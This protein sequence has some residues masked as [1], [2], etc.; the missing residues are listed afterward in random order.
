MRTGYYLSLL[1][2]VISLGATAQLKTPTKWTTSTSKD[3]IKAGDELDLIF[4]AKID[5]DWYLYSNDFDPECGPIVTEFKFKASDAFELVGAVKPIN[6]VVKHDKNFGCDVKIFKEKGEF[7][8]RIRVRSIPVKVEVA[9]SYQTCTDIDGRCIPGEEEFVFDK[10]NTG[11]TIAEPPKKKTEIISVAAAPDTASAKPD[12]AKTDPVSTE[13]SGPVLKKS[14]LEGA[15]TLEQESFLGFLVIAFLAGLTSLITPCIFPMIPMTVT[16]F[17]KDNQTRRQGIRKALI[18]GIS[19]I[20]IYTTL[21]TLFAVLLGTEGLNALATNWALNLFVFVI[22]IVFALSFFG[23]FEITA[24]YKL[25]NKMD[26]QAEKGGLTGI[27]FMAATLCLVSF[28]CTVPIVGS[29]LLLASGGAIIKPILVMFAYSVAFGVPFTI[30]AI[31]PEAIKRLPKSGGWLNAVKVSLGCLELALCFK[32]FSIADQ[33]YHWG[34]LDRDTNLALWI[35]IFTILGFYLLGKIRLPHDSAMESVGV[36]RLMLAIGVFTF[37][38]YLIP[39]LFGAPLKALAGYLPPKFTLDFDLDASKSGPA[40]CDVPKYEDFLHLPHGIEGYFDYKQAVLCARK[41]NKPVFIDFTG[42]GCTNCR[43]MEATVWSDPAVLKRLKND[44]IVVALYVDDKTEL[45]PSEWVT[46]KAD[47][48]VKKTIGKVNADIQ[49]ANL[50]N[51][52]QPYY[53]LLGPDETVLAWPY[54]YDKSP[55]K[56]V[57]FLER[58]KSKFRELY[59]KQ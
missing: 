22:F 7:R 54:A 26:S 42:H 17:L 6:A 48:K 16:F 24:P 23:L 13:I 45:P 27:F 18:F 1:F 28:S 4:S 53:V 35:V 10:F 55:K 3:N 11:S 34:L 12:V 30:F 15:S 32:F 49:I 19:I 50:E 5:K 29:V 41:Q 58:G 40:E 56:F 47:G 37:V 51:N 25:V 44:F 8:Q 43:E 57:E 14:I 31:F 2:L 38:V 39:G 36:I 20:T 33:A 21:G 9:V 52:A 59:S 46:S